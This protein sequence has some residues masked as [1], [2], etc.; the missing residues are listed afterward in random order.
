MEQIDP[1]GKIFI[2]LGT[3]SFARYPAVH[4]PEGVGADLWRLDGCRTIGYS[5]ILVLRE[6][7]HSIQVKS[8]L[9]VMPKVSDRVSLIGGSGM[10]GY[11]FIPS[12]SP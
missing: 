12:H 4:K 1:D 11:V 2:S 8:E 3:A 9:E 5:Q 10:G 6:I 7:M